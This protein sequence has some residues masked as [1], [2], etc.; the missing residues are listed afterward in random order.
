MKRLLFLLLLIPALS[1]G[2]QVLTVDGKVLT[3]G[4][5]VLYVPTEPD[6]IT[7]LEFW[8]D[9]NDASTFTLDGTSVDQ[10]DDKSGNA[11]HVS[12]AVDATRPTY[13]SATG[14]V[15]FITANSTF[16]ASA[17][18]GPLNQPNTIFVVCKITG[19]LG[20]NEIV[21][22]GQIG[23]SD[24]RLAQI[25]D[26][27]FKMYAGSF[28]ANIASNA[29][30][31]IHLGEFNGAAS[32]YWINGVLNA[33]G[34]AGANALSGVTLGKYSGGGGFCDCEI[35]EVFGYNKV[36]T[37]VQ[38]QSLERYVTSKWGL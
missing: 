3:D 17:A 36:L 37:T 11:R 1:F 29:N 30:D 4:T 9:G 35:M 27:D 25:H 2:Q 22:S 7:G 16:L 28:I 23:G 6:D 34:D 32:K 18:F 12:N 24:V 8:Y 19:A 15:T 13:S 20:D 31:N 38:R 21:F 10:W 26:N 14:R 33:S 5:N